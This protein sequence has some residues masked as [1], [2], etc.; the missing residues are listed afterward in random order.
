MGLA[1]SVCG[2]FS[3]KNELIFSIDCSP[4]TKKAD[5]GGKFLGVLISLRVVDRNCFYLVI[6]VKYVISCGVR[7]LFLFL[8][9]ASLL[10]IFFHLLV[11]LCF[12]FGFVYL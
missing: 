10:D 11:V 9:C 2:Y 8:S 5:K 1:V 6:L 4:L 7:M 12:N 3:I